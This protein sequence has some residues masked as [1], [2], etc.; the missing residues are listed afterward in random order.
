M[1]PL[2]RSFYTRS[3]LRV[4]KDLLGKII[5][6]KF[7]RQYLAGTIVET[8]AYLFNDPACHA[9]RNKTNRNKVMFEKGGFLYVYFT[10]GMHYCVNVVT[11][12]AGIGEAVLIRAVEPIKGIKVIAQNRKSKI[13]VVGKSK[14]CINLTNGPAKFAEAFAISKKESGIDLT[15]KTIFICNG[16]SI[17]S[18]KRVS[19]VRIGITVA[20]EKKWRY[21]IKGND[22]VSKK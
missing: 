12:K 20:K 11:Y 17:P 22:W 8:E 6:R 9:Y 10:Y 5:V 4:A 14:Q 19:T 13:N 2:P 15:K 1:K 21:Y 3:T 16:I 7:G 18:S